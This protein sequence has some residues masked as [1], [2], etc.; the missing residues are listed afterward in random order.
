MYG[1]LICQ[2]KYSLFHL[3]SFCDKKNNLLSEYH[4]CSV[5]LIYVQL[6]LLVPSHKIGKLFQE[7]RYFSKLRFYQELYVHNPDLTMI[8][9][10]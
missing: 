6:E 8:D 9:K 3:H 5:C 7:I 1:Q 4:A 10:V 2:C